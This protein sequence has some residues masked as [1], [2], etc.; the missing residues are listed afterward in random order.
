[1]HTET[2]I[3]G[4]SL[5]CVFEEPPAS[6]VDPPGSAASWAACLFAA[7]PGR[8]ECEIL[9]PA[10]PRAPCSQRQGSASQRMCALELARS[11]APPRAVLV[12]VS[13]WRGL[14]RGDRGLQGR[15]GMPL[16]SA[17]LW[18]HFLRSAR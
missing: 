11:R 10:A 9:S 12:L 13:R 3:W 4:L 18:G 1:M 14:A 2:E 5:E 16:A 15:C 17:Q 6:T 7:F 8:L